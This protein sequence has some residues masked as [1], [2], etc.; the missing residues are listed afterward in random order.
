MADMKKIMS[1]AF[2]VGAQLD[3]SLNKAIAEVKKLDAEMQGF[4]DKAARNKAL[5]E[6]KEKMQ[7]FNKASANMSAAWGKVAN[8]I[9]GPVKTI[10]KVGMA[11]GAAVYG[12]SAATA[13][14]GDDAVKAAKKIGMTTQEYSKLAY[15]AE[16]SNVSQETLSTSLK[17]LNINISHAVQGNKEAQLAFK[18]AGVNIY[19]AGGKL[20]S[21]NQI[22]LEA[23]DM[24]AKMPEGIYKAD[25]AM[26]LFGKSGSEM[27]PLMEQGSAEINKLRSEAEKLGIVFNDEEGMRATGFMDSMTTLK[28]ALKGVGI[29]VGKHLHAPL[30]ELNKVFTEWIVAN[31]EW[32]GLKAAEIIEKFKN[33]IPEIKEFLIGAKD[34]VL[35]FAKAID[36]IA[37]S[38][39]GWES[40]VKKT[41]KA[42]SMLSMLKLV[43]HTFQAA[44]A[45]IH[46]VKALGAVAPLLTA[47]KFG[48]IIG[49]FKMI[50]GIIKWFFML[51]KANPWILAI[52]LII[53]ALTLLYKNWDKIK[54][55]AAAAADEF[56]R[57]C[58]VVKSFFDGFLNWVLDS[59]NLVIDGA[60]QTFNEFTETFWEAI[61]FIKD[62]FGGIVGFFSEKIDN[63]KAAFSDGFLNGIVQIIKEFHPAALL[64]D[65]I[66][67]IFGIDLLGIGKSW[68]KGL[69]DG[70]LNGILGAAGAVKEAVG[71]LIPAPIKNAVGGIKNAV[72]GIMPFAEGGIVT[73]PQ[74]AMVGEDGP[75]A[76]VPLSKPSRAMEIM[77][78]VA[79]QLQPIQQAAPMVEPMRNAPQEPK[80][81]QPIEQLSKITN[82]Y[83][84]SK[85]NTNTSNFTFS[86]NITVNGGGN[87]VDIK[88]AISEALNNA[89]GQ[90]ER[91]IKE[92]EHNASRVAM[93]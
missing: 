75:E 64:N 74:F 84:N 86:P 62:I 82:N 31:R 58:G 88:A 13:K 83:N 10:A 45:T 79:P 11:A 55:G 73:K 30:T 2:Q 26:A 61:D 81:S 87:A 48:T 90:F 7:D 65:A 19:D 44:G 18:R 49:H 3:P 37:Q 39:G 67:A 68:I 9:L 53:G 40:T 47:M 29:V 51:A 72:S 21:T 23:S 1:L 60:I 59:W 4:Q 52:T 89:K 56:M 80:E 57:C 5:N 22:F 17:K 69:I 15:A 43:G 66:N 32:I 33:H 28:G 46:F 92:R 42:Y 63:I 35:S 36:G 76:I 54:A 78:Q 20:K 91:W 34:S 16:L 24:F 41:A 8:D 93:A 27:V 25:L 6:L 50:G 12:L 71:N 38:M 70:I 85:A 77:Q 14:F